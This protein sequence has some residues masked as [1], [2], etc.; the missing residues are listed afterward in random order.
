MEL[1]IA[2]VAIMTF[3]NTYLSIALKLVLP[4]D[5][6]LDSMSDIIFLFYIIFLVVKAVGLSF[7]INFV[8]HTDHDCFFNKDRTFL[9]YVIVIFVSLYIAECILLLESP[10][11]LYIS[12]T[13]LTLAVFSMLWIKIQMERVSE[14]I[15]HEKERSELELLQRE[16]DL[17]KKFLASQE[18]LH[19]LKHDVQHILNTLAEKDN[20]T[21]KK[22]I[23]AKFDSI[24]SIRIPY[25]TGNDA[26]DNVLN[27]KRDV[28]TSKGIAFIC[29]TNIDNDLIFSDEDLSLIMINLLDNAIEHIGKGNRIEV[30]I[31]KIGT[32][33]LVKISNSID[34]PISLVGNTYKIPSNYRNGYGVKTVQNI[35]KKYGGILNCSNENTMLI[36]T[37]SVSNDHRIL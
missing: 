7:L 31:K 13:I 34:S 23:N 16:L 29:V 15:I 25:D 6:T 35:V 30:F 2:P 32:R 20:E 10:F 22:E 28:A 9:M 36:S 5:M 12:S 11:N 37:I 24:S 4:V 33:L 14:S 17:N 3:V 27:V 19:I 8:T 26:L 1:S 21:L 18:E